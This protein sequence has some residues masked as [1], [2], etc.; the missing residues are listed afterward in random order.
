MMDSV[1]SV[2]KLENLL[3]VVVPTDLD[4][5]EVTAL[6]RAV[7]RKISQHRPRKVLLDFSE[8]DIC[9]TFFGRFIHSMV[10]MAS[11]M[12]TGVVVSGLQDSVI[13]TMVEMG[14][15]LSEVDATL[16][17][18]DAIARYRAEEAESQSDP[19][20]RDIERAPLERE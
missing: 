16:D 3:L 8:V 18:D 20:D 9:D 13:E 4:D 15:V 19:D 11:L 1:V 2:Q 14:M 6:R 5:E 10:G 17:L 7:L 12:G